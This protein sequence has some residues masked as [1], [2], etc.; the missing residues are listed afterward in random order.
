MVPEVDPDCKVGSKVLI[1]QMPKKANL[2]SSKTSCTWAV[3][4][5][6]VGS[7]TLNPSPPFGL[8]FISPFMG[9]CGCVF[10]RERGYKGQRFRVGRGEGVSWKGGFGSKNRG[11]IGV[12]WYG[13]GGEWVM[14]GWVARLKERM[15]RG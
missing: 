9:C 2:R 8:L 7:L 1:A 4:V 13:F 3:L 14:E 5:V 12:W 15:G 11:T 6:R 10:C